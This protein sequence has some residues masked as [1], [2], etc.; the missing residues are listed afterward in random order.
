MIEIYH[1]LFIGS[2]DSRKNWLEI[3]VT[4]A[5]DPWF[6]ELNLPATQLWYEDDKQLILNLVDADDISYIPIP[7]IEKALNFIH[8][9]IQQHK[10][11]LHCNYGI[12]RSPS[13]GFLYLLKHTDIFYS[14]S[15]GE[16]IE[17]FRNIYKNWYPNRG[18]A[19]FCIMYF[20]KIKGVI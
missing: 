3:I 15:L 11:L 5:R 19:L 8:N 1:N 14:L 2:A 13:V 10:I 17:K 16:S 20:K 6:K 7:L 12:S 18:M 9:N 4:A